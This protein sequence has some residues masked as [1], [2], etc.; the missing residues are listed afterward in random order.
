M[1]GNGD[2]MGVTD[3]RS[4]PF[5]TGQI[6]D[7]NYSA[8]PLATDQIYGGG[9]S[10]FGGF[11]FASPPQEPVY[12]VPPITVTGQQTNYWLV[13]VGALALWLVLRRR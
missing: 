4:A 10:S 9:F 3:P 1:S 7:N 11:T 13:V 8:A 2:N 6:S 12:Q 5:V